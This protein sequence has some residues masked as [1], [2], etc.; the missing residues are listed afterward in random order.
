MPEIDVEIVT[1]S[2]DM[3]NYECAMAFMF[4]FIPFQDKP[5]AERIQKVECINSK[6][7]VH[8][9]PDTPPAAGEIIH[10]YLKGFKDGYFAEKR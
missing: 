10:I 5:I 8:F 4:T 6:V 2:E 7:V 3:G 9:K 1:A